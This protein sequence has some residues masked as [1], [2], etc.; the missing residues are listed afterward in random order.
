MCGFAGEFIFAGGR[1][2]LERARRM[3]SLLA[4]RGPDSAGEFLS[5]DGRCAIGFRRLAVIDPAGS[6][7]PMSTADGA[8]TLACNGEIYNYRELRRDLA[9]EGATFRTAGDVE[10]LLPLYERHGAELTQHIEGMFAFAIYDATR[11]RLLLVRDRLGQKPLW[12]AVLPDR[13]VFASEAKALLAHPLVDRRVDMAALTYYLTMG[14][15]PAPRSAWAGIRKLGPAEALEVSDRVCEP[16]RYWSPEPAC[17]PADQRALI[18][19]TRDR[20]ARSVEAHMVSDVPLGALLSGGLDSSIVVALMCKSVGR[21]GGVRT[22]TAGFEQD[23]FDERPYARLVAERFRTEHTELV[24]RPDPVGLPEM[25]VS[26]YDEP[27]GD[28]S[29]LPTWLICREARAHVK[30]ALAGDGGDEVF[31]GYD[32]HRAMYMAQCMRPWTYVAVRVAAAAARPFAARDERSRLRRLVRFAAGLPYPFAEQYFIYR[33][34]FGPADLQR[35]LTEDVRRSIDVEGPC[36]WFL[37]LY[38]D[39]GL[40][41]ELARAQRHDMLTYLPDD[42]LVKTDIASMAASLEV[43]APM[44]DRHVVGLGLGLPDEVKV[45]RGR[46]KEILR[47]AFGDLLPEEIVARPKRGFGVPLGRWL[48]EE[49]RV[50]LED[51]LLDGGLAKWGIFEPGAIRGLVN[52]HLSDRDDHGHR[53]WA[54]LVLATWLERQTGVAAGT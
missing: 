9:A 8:V 34:L 2:D 29:A 28:S 10:V 7:Q 23:E 43:R 20:L 30:V 26:M 45:G 41:G 42:L 51:R 22:F 5:A 32:R 25:I 33:R 38:E 53:L 46:G 21:A 15:I 1:A 18:D 17:V 14:Y 12:Y 54:L 37:D 36:R 47:A 24:V 31:G 39:A 50:T 11:Q 27:F 3:A 49:L 52:D 40:D 48:R 44:L 19:L 35:L 16:R 6:D 13:V 4:H